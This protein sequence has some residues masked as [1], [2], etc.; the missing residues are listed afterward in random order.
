MLNIKIKRLFKH[1]S[2]QFSVLFML[3]GITVF[4]V[5]CGK[6]RPPQPPIERSARQAT[7]R[8]EQRGSMIF[9]E[10]Q[11]PSAGFRPAEILRVDIFRLAEPSN[12]LTPLS[13][14]DFAARSNIIGSVNFDKSKPSSAQNF[15]TD[16]LNNPTPDVRLQY[17][18]RFVN[19]ENQSGSFSNFVAVVPNLRISLPPEVLQ[20]R[21]V[22]EGLQISWRVTSQTIL[23][24][25]TIAPLGVNIYRR[26]GNEDFIKINSEPFT[27]ETF[28][29][30]D[31]TEN[32]SYVYFLRTVTKDADGTI[33]ESD[34]S[35][36]ISARYKDTFAPAPP[37]GLTIAAAPSKL[38][39]FF[40]ANSE[41]DVAG[42]KIYR[43]ENALSDWQSALL[44]TKTPIITT[45]FEDAQVESGKTYFYFVTAVDKSGNESRPSEIVSEKAP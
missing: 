23:P 35:Q 26:S 4:G 43:S 11:N 36:T 30:T 2:A 16:T 15:Y 20:T 41:T 40:A 1:N 12:T 6:R 29:D 44:L 19:R 8:A 39:L 28:T 42:Y 27:K 45:A 32:N 34:N 33:L 22:P 24:N 38:A 37:Q 10:W 9:L 31:V 14:E 3:S 18:V 13:E 21:S 7:L 17:A 25:Q 5:G